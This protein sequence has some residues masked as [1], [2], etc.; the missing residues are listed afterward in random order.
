MLHLPK[1]LIGILL[2]TGA[3]SCRTQHAD[4]AGGYRWISPSKISSSEISMNTDGSFQYRYQAGDQYTI[5]SDGVWRRKRGH[6]ILN[7]RID[8]LSDV[9]DVE[10]LHDPSLPPD[11]KRISIVD[12][13]DPRLGAAFIVNPPSHGKIKFRNR[14]YVVKEMKLKNDCIRE[15]AINYMALGPQVIF[16]SVR[17]TT[18]NDIC[19]HVKQYSVKTYRFFDHE[20]WKW[21]HNQ[22]IDG[23]RVFE[24][25]MPDEEVVS[26][27]SAIH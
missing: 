4:I 15:V 3:F 26:F 7:T 12:V 16:Y 27:I 1:V 8:S 24:K 19:I 13:Y 11:K 18:A 6:V 5:H 9:I 17:D 14:T 20:K 2:L 23:I 22:L 10:E 21:R 25:H